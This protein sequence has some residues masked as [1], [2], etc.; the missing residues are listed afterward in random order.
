[1][2]LSARWNPK[3]SLNTWIRVGASLSI[4]A[5]FLFHEAEWTQ[6]RFI[7]QLE[8]WAYDTRLRL[9]MPNTLDPRVVI[10]DIDEKSLN[11]EGRW[12][13]SRNKVALMV[14]QLFDTYKV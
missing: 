3:F 9:F 11:A 8:L 10:L 2:K 5:A 4:V 14:R 12:P 6:F 13:W 1:M 7:Q